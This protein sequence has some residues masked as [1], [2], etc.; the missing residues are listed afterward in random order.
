MTSPAPTRPPAFR[1]KLSLKL[2]DR[3]RIELSVQQNC[4]AFPAYEVGVRDALVRSFQSY[5]EEVERLS[6]GIHPD[7]LSQYRKVLIRV[8]R[9]R[10]YL[11]MENGEERLVGRRLRTA[12]S[13]LSKLRA[14][15][16]GDILGAIQ[17][18]LA[19]APRLDNT[20]EDRELYAVDYILSYIGC[21]N[22]REHEEALRRKLKRD[23]A[24]VA[25]NI[26]QS[27]RQWSQLVFD[28][29]TDAGIKCVDPVQYPK[30]FFDSFG[31]GWVDKFLPDIFQQ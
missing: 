15:M 18:V 24:A 21:S 7:Q 19:A 10:N 28:L 4:E 27:K 23:L 26:C 17:G 16:S 13:A 8:L 30:K 3:R 2:L 1:Y 9:A 22:S 20:R 25:W 11:S 31:D 14:K 6:V 29:M 5:N 12:E